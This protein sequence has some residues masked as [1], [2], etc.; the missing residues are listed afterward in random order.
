MI[1]LT[2]FAGLLV[3]VVGAW[4]LVET[5]SRKWWLW[6]AIPTLVAWPVTIYE[7]GSS[8][9]GYATDAPLPAEFQLVSSYADEKRK[10]VF[11]LVKPK[12]DDVARFY[13]VTGDFESNRKSFAKAQGDVAKGVPTAGRS[14]PG[15]SSEGEFVF[16]RLPPVGLPE[17]G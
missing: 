6:L 11:A 9:L 2:I 14:R 7:Y 1:G 8:L 4:L 5:G 13:A 15:Q 3:A 12:G 10:T 17:K 16:Y